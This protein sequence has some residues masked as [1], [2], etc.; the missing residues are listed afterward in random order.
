MSLDTPDDVLGMSDEDFLKLNDPES[1]GSGSES[2]VEETPSPSIPEADGGA[3]TDPEASAAAPTESGEGDTNASAVDPTVTPT[4]PV[5]DAGTDAGA[6]DQ[7]ELP[8]EQPEGDTTPFKAP[9]N[10]EAQAFFVQVMKPFKANGKMIELRSPDE[11]VSLMQMGANYTRKMQELQPHRKT[12][13][14]LQNNNLL[15]PDKLSFLIDLDRGDPEAVKKFV[16]DRGIDPL[17]IDTST[18][19]AYLGGNHQVTDEE[20]TF[21]A[22]LEEISSTPAGQEVLQE[23]SDRWDNTSKEVLWKHPEILGIIQ[24]Q[25][26]TGVYAA[27]VAE[28]DRQITVGK[29]RADMPFLEA[30]KAVGDQ[31]YSP[32]GQ[33]NAGTGTVQPE[34]QPAAPQ[35]LATRV[36]TP[37]STPSN[38]DKA[39]AASPTRS[40]PKTASNFVN[41]L[42][43]SDDDFL[44][45]ME[46]RV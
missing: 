36:A 27:I 20:A 16:K 12:L 9:S 34:P 2:P 19:P 14:M 28:M 44:K 24:T 46:N 26:E 30:Y 37:K 1:L 18:D 25:R 29:L 6:G 10:E 32:S 7:G 41:P 11:A 15:D 3:V 22:T 23:V 39:V 45:L 43:M 35:V 40:T 33:A 17:D 8:L 5:P 42:S 21:R 38:H 13:L 4:P 31:L